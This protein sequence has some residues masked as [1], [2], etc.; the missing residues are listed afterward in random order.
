MKLIK[1][2]RRHNL[3]HKGYGLAFKFDGWN[4]HASMVEIAVQRLEGYHW[5]NTF[6]GKAI[7]SEFGY[8]VVRPYYIAVKN[9]STATMVLLKV[10]KTNENMDHK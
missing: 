8:I 9:E 4:T 7:R 2:D 1:L 6:W 3:Y 5:N 10:G